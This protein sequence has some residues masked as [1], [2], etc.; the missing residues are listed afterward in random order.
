[1]T[2][3]G[4][5]VPAAP[6]K[7]L[8]AFGDTDLD[9]LFFFG[10]ERESEVIAANLIA[11]RLTVLYGP[12]GVGKSSVLRAGAARRLRSSAPDAALAVNDAWAGDPV[13]AIRDAVAAAAPDLAPPPAAAPLADALEDWTRRST[14]ELYL[15][16][17]QFE[18]LFVYHAGGGA[19]TDELAR[20]V[21]RPGLRVNVLIAIRA[22]ALAELDVF[23][24][25]VA[26]VFGNHLPLDRLDREAG[27]SAIVGP[28]ERYNELVGADDRVEIEPELVDAVLDEVAAGRVEIGAAGQGTAAGAAR[29]DAVEAPFL[30][31]VMERL[32]EAERDRGSRILRRDTL[33]AMGGAEAIVR[34]HLER[35]V[36]ALA[37]AERDVAA[38][39]FNHLVTPSGT[40][41]AHRVGDLALYA[42]IGEDELR[43]ILAT[44]GEER[45]LRPLDGRY[46]IFHDVLADAVAAW[47]VRYE[48]RRE[49]ERRHRRTLALAALALVS[50]AVMG[51]ITIFALAQRRDAR[52]SARRAQARELTARASVELSADP[53]RSLALGVAAAALEPT[54]E[55]EAVLRRA[56]LEAQLRGTLRVGEPVDLVA[57]SPDGRRVLAAGGTRIRLWDGQPRRALWTRTF[58]APVLAARFHTGER[59][60]VATGRGVSELD[61]GGG[62]ETA[63]FRAPGRLSSASFS[64]DGAAA[65]VT[66]GSSATVLHLSTCETRTIEQPG[67]A[68]FGRLSRDGRTV[69]VVGE[70]TDLRVRTRLYDAA[71]GRPLAVLDEQRVTDAEF[72][73]DGTVLATA[74]ADGVTRL[75]GARSG[76]SIDTLSDE[77]GGVTDLEFDAGGSLLATGGLD[78]AVRV[79]KVRTGERFF[80]FVEHTGP[81]RHVAFSPDG[82]QLASTSAD[83]TGRLWFTGGIGSAGRP[84]ALLAGHG[85]S[86]TTADFA[87]DGRTL[88]TGSEDG[89][90]RLWNAQ[91]EQPLGLL[92]EEVAPVTAAAFSPNG[93]FVVDATAAGLA[94]TRRARDGQPVATLD[95]GAPLGQAVFSPDSRLVLTAGDRVARLWRRNG[96]PVASLRHRA[97]VTRAVFASDGT[98]VATS[99]EDGTARLWSARDGRLLATLPH[100]APVSDVALAPEAPLAVTGGADGA[101]RLWNTRSG[102]RLRSLLGHEGAIVRV[103]FSPDGDRI[104]SAGVDATARLWSVDGAQLHVLRGH[105]SALTNARFDPSGARVVTTGAGGSRNAM[106]WD[107]RTGRLLHVLVGHGGGV[108]GAAFSADGRWVVTAGPVSGGVWPTATG[109]L[110]FY[111]RGHTDLL[112]SA[113]FSPSGYRVLTSARDGTVRA[114]DC[115]VCRPVDG[116]VALAR[117][118]L[119]AARG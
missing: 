31:L 95:H 11:S 82:S 28:L 35:A 112:T 39:I 69:A 94:R 41:I 63:V 9:A 51:A 29:S 15:V 34:A 50:L 61:A 27:R 26:N 40:K 44:L 52:D 53:Q 45:I 60:L 3:L 86:V 92:G 117:A 115:L 109:R 57:H 119:A 49:L 58:G 74:A 87:P 91:I 79:W 33:A 62:E 75:W 18:E 32:W 56:L 6:Y 85:G 68:H 67:R 30:Q 118:R 59:V 106:L 107:A 111:L 97:N 1:M 25:R 43:P 83:R 12:S 19:L 77:G 5:S 65:V 14:G 71:S 22:D 116:L 2:E 76:T 21:N 99:S 13:Q 102:A 73:P 113:S 38:R 23:T 64:A 20:V 66:S 105:L 98:V 110:A 100:G 4:V 16:L 89:T 47:R 70:G 78:G 55:V 42:R 108:S 84:A 103:A 96:E 36:G 88:V 114:Y 80:F 93:R 7:G 90:A 54:R 46:E 72:S 81:I 48:A 17:D 104:L 24:G 37:S 8:A 10:R 101:V